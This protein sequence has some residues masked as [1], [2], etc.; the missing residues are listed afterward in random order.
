LYACGEVP[1]P[2]GP[3]AD[4]HLARPTVTT[5]SATEDWLRAIRVETAR[6]HSTTLAQATGYV[7]E[8]ICVSAP[9]LGG[10][11]YHWPNFSLVDPVFAPLHPEA[12]LYERGANGKFHLIGLEYVVIDVGQPDPEFAGQ[13]FDV[14]GVPPLEDAGVPHFSLHLWLY[15]DNPSGLFAPFNPEV[16][17]P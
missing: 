11:G 9:G 14:G 5:G 17:C 10:M 6:F 3:H 15:K 7:R 8:D 16:S 2:L 4:A 13:P 12:L 1:G